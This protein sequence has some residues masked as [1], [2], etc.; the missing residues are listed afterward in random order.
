[1]IIK[2]FYLKEKLEE[3]KIGIHEYIQFYFDNDCASIV[4]S[5]CNCW[6]DLI[7]MTQ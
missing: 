1:M 5:C 3:Y 6:V 2:L 7:E 4:M